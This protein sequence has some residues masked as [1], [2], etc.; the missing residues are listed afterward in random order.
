MLRLLGIL[1]KI[2]AK[3]QDEIINGAGTWVN[4]ISPNRLQNLLPGNY[5]S[6]A[7]DKEFKQHGFLLGENERTLDALG[8]ERDKIDFIRT[9]GVYLRRVFRR[10]TRSLD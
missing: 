3:L 2:A 10:L 6:L 7:I 1:L 4:I 8:F 9:E 5:F